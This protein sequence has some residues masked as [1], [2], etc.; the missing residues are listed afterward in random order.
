M[1]W[2]GCVER[3][4]SD[5]VSERMLRLELPGKNPTGRPKRRYM[6]VGKDLRVVGVGEKDAEERVTCMGMI[7]HCNLERETQKAE[8]NN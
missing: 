8:T 3:R 7:H 4:D 5:D 6:K 2:F 1:R